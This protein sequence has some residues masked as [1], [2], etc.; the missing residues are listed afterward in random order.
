MPLLTRRR[1]LAAKIETTVGTAETLA[2]GDAGFNIFDAK[3]SPQIETDNRE[4]QGGFSPLTAVPGA[5]GGQVT[6]AVELHGSGSA[7]APVPA[8]ASTFLPACGMYDDSDTFRLESKPPEAA[9]AN[10]KTL[11]IGVYED[12][13]LKRIRGAM[14]TFNMVMASGKVIRLEFTF[15]GI[16]MAPSDVAILAPTYPTVIPPRFANSA[17]DVGGDWTPRV[18]E[19]NIDLGNDVQLRED[20]TDVSAYHSAVIVDRETG[21]SMDP[22]ATSVADHDAYGDWLRSTTGALTIDIGSGSADGNRIQIAAPAFQIVAPDEGD[23]NKIQT[24]EV[25]F[26]LVRSA[27]AGDDELT[28]AFS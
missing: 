21:G 7:G 1:V 27:A 17:L 18:A 6:F 14:G 9:G 4:G 25:D 11:T 20:S 8:W 22:E 24:N 2:A 12:G 3:I 10:T 23:R 26:R 5:R 19:M 15:T 28:M 16:W 13:L